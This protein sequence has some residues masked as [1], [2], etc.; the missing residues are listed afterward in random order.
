MKKIIAIVALMLLGIV[1]LSAQIPQKLSYQAVIRN[2]VGNVV[3]DQN[4]EVNVSILKGSIDGLAVYTETH[5]TCTSAN[6]V[7]TLEIGGGVSTDN[8]SAIDWSNGPFF[9]RSTA[10]LNGKVV[11]VTSQLL[12][13]PYA[14][15]AHRSFLANK[16]DEDFLN[17]F[18][19]ARVQAALAERDSLWESRLNALEENLKSLTE[20][21]NVTPEIEDT[22]VH[23]D[24]PDVPSDTVDVPIDTINTDTVQVPVVPIEDTIS[25]QQDTSDVDPVDTTA[26]VP[27]VTPMDTVKRSA[28]KHGILPGSIGG[29]HFSQGVLQFHAEKN[30][31]RF[32]ETQFD[33]LGKS[34]KDYEFLFRASWVD[35]YEFAASCSAYP[36]FPKSFVDE[37]PIVIPK[38]YWEYHNAISN[39]GNK[40]GVWKI[41]S[42]TDWWHILF[43]RE[44][45][46]N[47][48]SKAEVDG[49]RGFLLLPDDWILPSGLTFTPRS[50]FDVNVYDK[51]QW[52]KMEAAGAVFFPLGYYWSGFWDYSPNCADFTEKRPDQFLDYS[53]PGTCGFSSLNYVRLAIPDT[54]AK[55]ILDDETIV[56]VIVPDDDD[57]STLD[58]IMA[59]AKIV[60]LADKEVDTT[61]VDMNA[62]VIPHKFS[63]SESTQ[64]YFSQGNLLYNEETN[65]WRFEEDFFSSSYSDSWQNLFTW[66]SSG[67][68]NPN[69]RNPYYNDPYKN[70]TNDISGTKYDWGVYNSISNGGNVANLWRT[71]SSNE[72]SYLLSRKKNEDQPLSALALVNNNLGYVL[73]PDD[74]VT[75]PDLPLSNSL[76][77]GGNDYTLEQ[78]REMEALGAVFLPCEGYDVDYDPKYDLSNQLSRNIGGYWSSSSFKEGYSMAETF[79]LNMFSSFFDD[80]NWRDPNPF[81]YLLQ[82]GRLGSNV[83][84]RYCVRLVRDVKK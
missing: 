1:S 53:F 68:Q 12:S 22:T 69:N 73:L 20:H 13:V 50:S 82:F 42:D 72:W 62:G 78:W 16:V 4:L 17:A 26:V 6:G 47:L 80:I 52:A 76:Y 31:W 19:E 81:S 2:S 8:F 5:S 57:F 37:S 36:H 51:T 29:F 44:N 70:G 77:P 54:E 74:W 79:Y 25:H 61:N 59:D 38:E 32:A 65:E 33:T 84:S 71:L 28:A 24:V 23:I 75:N 14:L 64:V 83:L 21:P 58:S 43:D 48:Y 67:Y 39:G 34:Y 40:K 60:L 18:V 45:A 7:V 66:S 35:K 15:F 55:K 56:D 11:S 30:V 63:V 49:M 46:E 3:S 10:E 9:V 27:V 41:L